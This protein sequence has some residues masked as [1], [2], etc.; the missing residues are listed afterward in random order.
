M[1]YFSGEAAYSTEFECPDSSKDLEIDLGDL[2]EMATVFVNGNKVGALWCVPYVLR[3]P[4]KVLKTGKNLLEIRVTNLS[5]NRIIK[6]D[7]DKV[8]WRTFREINFVDIKYRPFDASKS[9]PV[10]S[11]LSG[12]IRMRE[13]ADSAAK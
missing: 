7:I 12:E 9:A 1:L 3:I 8:K 13:L 5:F 2:R 10:P 11:G 6:M 4:S